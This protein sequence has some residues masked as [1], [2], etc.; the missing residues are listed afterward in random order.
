MLCVKT[1][2]Y[3]IYADHDDVLRAIDYKYCWC[4]LNYVFQ[5][6]IT[7]HVL[8]ASIFGMRLVNL[9]LCNVH[10]CRMSPTTHTQTPH[11]TILKKIDNVPSHFLKNSKT[12]KRSHYSYG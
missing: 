6:K 4:F 3:L 10:I 5:E 8:C 1:S 2:E 9:F 12:V 7:L 11:A